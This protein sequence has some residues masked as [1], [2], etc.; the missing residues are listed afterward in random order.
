MEQLEAFAATF[1]GL[2]WNIP[3][4]GLLFIAGAVFTILNRGVQFTMFRHA[5]DIVRGKF[6]NPN[7]K[8]EISH[9]Q[10]L[11]AA[12]SATIGLGNIAGV[13][14]AITA[15]GPG[16]VFWMWVAALL[17]MATKYTSISL[18]LI[19]REQDD[20][21]H[22]HGGPMYTM[23]NGLGGGFFL[24]MAGFYAFATILSSFGAGNMFQSKNVAETLTASYGVPN[25]ASGVVLCVFAA[26]VLIGGIKRIGEVAGKLVPLMVVLYFTAAIGIIVWNIGVVPSLLASIVTDAFTGQAVAGGFLGVLIQG[27]RRAVFSN[28]AGMGSAAMAHSA[29]KVDLPIREGIVGSLGPFIDTIVVCT[30]TALVVLIT[31]VAGGAEGTEGAALTTQAFESV[32]G[33]LGS[34]LLNVAIVLFAFSTIISWSYYGEQGVTYL[35][36]TKFIPAYRVIFICFTMVGALIPLQAVI[37][38]SDAVFGLMA[39][40]NILANLAL[41]RKLSG[42]TASYVKAYKAGEYKPYR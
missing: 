26:I 23:R 20:N 15:G 42:E 16:A 4:V 12:L 38:L 36:G 17:G 37:D 34:G 14:I 39:I 22:M 18:S 11:C 35:V 21:G 5:I 27:V 8:G 40:P 2:V 33:G 1:V 13:A 6:D 29:A 30:M 19:F 9:F 3:L 25:W 32:Y 41:T 10:A 24:A 31:G 7:S 28:E